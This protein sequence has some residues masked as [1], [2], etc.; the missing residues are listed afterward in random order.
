M[1]SFDSHGVAQVCF[2]TNNKVLCILKKKDLASELPRL[3]FLDHEG[4][5]HPQ[6]LGEQS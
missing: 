1:P 3:V 5:D 2:V 4:R 6:V